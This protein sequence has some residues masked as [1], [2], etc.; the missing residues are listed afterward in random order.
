MAPSDIPTLEEL[1]ARLAKLQDRDKIP[2]LEEIEKRFAK[3]QDREYVPSKEP[4]NE[5]DKLMDQMQSEIRLEKISKDLD[6]RKDQAIRDRLNKL[7][8]DSPITQKK[9]SPNLS[10][11]ET[12]SA[13][14]DGINAQEDMARKVAEQTEELEIRKPVA[15]IAVDLNDLGKIAADISPELEKHKDEILGI[16]AKTLNKIYESIKKITTPA[17]D[18]LKKI[19]NTFI[20]SIKSF[21]KKSPDKNMEKAKAGLKELYKSYA[22]LKNIDLEKT[23]KILEKIDNIKDPRKIISLAPKIG[24]ALSDA[25]VQFRDARIATRAVKAKS[26]KQKL[27]TQKDK[28]SFNKTGSNF[29]P[30]PTPNV[31]RDSTSKGFKR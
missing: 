27:Q 20:D 8:E 19:G 2:S 31:K 4:T 14:I 10:F 22:D 3:L 7:R 17:V 18:I 16:F 26:M 5:V 30:T 12:K 11:N 29:C 1:E 15:K 25:R 9:I 28:M 13:I 6:N 21:S 24:K 23:K